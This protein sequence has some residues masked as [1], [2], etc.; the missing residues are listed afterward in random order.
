[1]F[2]AVI[3]FGVSTTIFG[4]STS[5]PLSLVALTV[6]GASDVVSVVVRGSLVQLETRGRDAGPRQCG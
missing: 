5:F 4:L 3:V 1:M 2:A 6:L